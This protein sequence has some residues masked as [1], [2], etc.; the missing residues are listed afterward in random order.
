MKNVKLVTC[1][2]AIALFGLTAGCKKEA[3]T[4]GKAHLHGHVEIEATAEEI[5]DAV[6]N[7]WYGATSASGTANANTTTNAT[8][9]F[10]FE[11][12]NKGDYYLSSSYTDTSGT[13]L[14]GGAAATI[15]KKSEEVE[16]HIHLE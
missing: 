2:T 3:G 6:V 5:P 8:G 12:L 14:T 13:V 10:E 11:G 9:E 1:L 15:K 7:I 16:V 4:G